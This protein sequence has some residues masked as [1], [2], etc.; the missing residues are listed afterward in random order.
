MPEAVEIKNERYKRGTSPPYINLAE[1]IAIVRSIYEQGGGQVSYDAMSRITGNTSTSSSFLKKLAA[2]KTYGLTTDSDKTIFL[3]DQGTA[4]AAPTSELSESQARKAA[5]VS[6]DVFN[7]IYERHKGK[8]LPVDEFLKN[9]IEQ[10]ALIPRELSTAWAT[11]FKESARAAGL[12]FDRLD[13]KTQVL[14]LP[15]SPATLSPTDKPDAHSGTTPT[16]PDASNGNSPNDSHLLRVGNPLSASGNVTH[17]VLSSGRTA[18]FNIPFEI[19]AQD[20]KRLKSYL[21]GLELIIDAA[22]DEPKEPPS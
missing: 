10:D 1:A 8:L 16:K 22:I 3:T 6:V 7:R 14:E 13:G 9:I 19:T 11:A 12:L 21:K 5:F 4:I 20:A 15:L 2:L 18:E 17:F